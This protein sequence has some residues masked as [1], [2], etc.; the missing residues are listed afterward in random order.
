M[1]YLNLYLMLFAAV[2]G[3]LLNLILVPPFG[4]I[5]AATATA[6]TYL[7]WTVT[8]MIVSEK[9]WRFGF[10]WTTFFKQVGLALLFMLY[11]VNFGYKINYLLSFGLSLLTILLLL[12]ISL[13]RT[14]RISIIERIFSI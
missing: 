7:L 8:S 3:V 12:F 13:D 11:F 1:T 10:C 14:S 2:V 5:G 9:L 6:I 4:A